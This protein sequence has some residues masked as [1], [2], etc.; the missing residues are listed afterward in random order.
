MLPQDL[1]GFGMMLYGDAERFGHGIGG[2]VIVGRSNAAGCEDVGINRSD[3]IERRHDAVLLVGDNAD[4]LEID[5]DFGQKGG[6]VAGVT[7][8]GAA[9]KNL[10]ADDQDGGGGGLS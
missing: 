1:D 2:D 4:F 9:G 10:V 3:G 8:A 5:A 6:D 7:V